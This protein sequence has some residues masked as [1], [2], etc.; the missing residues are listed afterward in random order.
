MEKRMAGK[1]QLEINQQLHGGVPDSVATPFLDWGVLETDTERLR[2]DPASIRVVF[3]SGGAD[4][5]PALYGERPASRTLGVDHARD[6]Q[7]R[8]LFRLARTA[9]LPKIGIC[10]G[11]QFLCVMAGGRLCQHLDGH[12][13]GRDQTH[14]LR[15]LE[16][17]GEVRDLECSSTHHQMQLPPPGAEVLAWAEPRLAGG[18]Y[19]N[20]DD[21]LIVLAVE[22][23]AVYYRQTRSLGFQ[24]HPEWVDPDH[25]CVAYA[26]RLAADRLG[27]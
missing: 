25:A 9:N 14:G 16:P 3:F 24:W 12:G 23:E 26:R 17:D 27:L 18:R 21:H 10:R 13:L 2:K 20:G 5:S 1:Y 8:E 4:V 6:E 15:A 19:F 7:E 22:Y 11:A